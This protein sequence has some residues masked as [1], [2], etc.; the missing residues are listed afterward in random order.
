MISIIIPT[1]DRYNHLI[2]CVKSVLKN[3]YKSIE[4]IIIDQS[5]EPLK[6]TEILLK[7]NKIKYYHLNSKNKSKAI[8]LALKNVNGDITTF[9]DDDCI[10]DKDWLRNINKTFQ[11][12][13]DI[14][15]VFG[16]VYPYNQE[17]NKDK[18]CP[19]I[20]LNKRKNIIIR[21][22]LHWKNIGFG[23]NMAYRREIF[24][25]IGGFKEWLGP[26]SIGIAAED[27]EFAIRCLAKGYKLLYNPK[28]IVYHNRWLTKE[29]CRRQNLF[30]SCGEVACYGYFGFQELNLGEKVVLDNFKDYFQKIRKAVKYI[31]TMRLIGFKILFYTTEELFFR[32]RGLIISWYY[33]NVDPL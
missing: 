8:N 4:I 24:N 7:S 2:K 17:E 33:S 9:T 14:I 5:Q 19:S 18:V 20:F 31:F 1:C 13:K 23:N 29:E 12:K 6:N 26:G 10:V 28:I 21:P 25:K 3:N 30:Y 15:G 32:L 27:A 11:Q 22:C 16:K